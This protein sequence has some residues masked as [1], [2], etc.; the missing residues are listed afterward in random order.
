MITIATL[1]AIAITS[2]MDFTG[3]FNFSALVLAPLTLIFWFIARLSKEEIGFKIG[4]FKDYVLALAYPVTV[5][6]GA[7]LIAFIFQK[8]QLQSEDWSKTWIN[9]AASCTIGVIMVMITEELFFRGWLWGTMIK[10]GL[11]P[12]RTL[13]FTAIAFTL[14][15]ISPVLSPTDY[16]LPIYQVPIYLANALFLGLIWGLLR[17]IS[18]SLL[19]A[20][21]SHAVWNAFAYSFFG[22]GINNGALG[23]QPVI[24]YGPEVGVVGIMLN[25]IFFTWLWRIYKLKYSRSNDS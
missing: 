13:L 10:N 16:G 1:V 6:G 17:L 3:Y 11:S 25:M 24:I 8:V 15:H 5:L 12:D 14:W 18:G 9:V 23:I 4:T 20:S 7:V 2:A 19:V 22:Y 21:V